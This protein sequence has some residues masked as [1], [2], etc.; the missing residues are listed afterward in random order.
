[1]TADEL[2]A[3]GR[4]AVACEGWR[5]LPGMLGWR[6]DNHGVPHP[7]RFVEGVESMEALA[8]T[9]AGPLLASGYA[10]CD[11]YWRSDD[12]MPDLTDPA[13][14]G[15]LLALVREAWGDPRLVAIYCEAVY[16][17]QSE[18]WAVQTADNRLPVAGE[19]HGS[20]AEALV[21]AL[22]AA[23]VLGG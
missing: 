2:T 16:P 14:L 8:G 12:I 9:G 11:G 7:I 6:P 17:G 15:C 4:R 3:L 20:E 23:S 19:G 1:M 21:A 18:G 22:E 10:T 5:W 13:T